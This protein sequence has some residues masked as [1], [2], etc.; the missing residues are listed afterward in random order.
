[1]IRFSLWSL[2]VVTRLLA[3]CLRGAVSYVGAGHWK[4]GPASYP[5]FIV[6]SWKLGNVAKVAWG[7]PGYQ[8][9]TCPFPSSTSARVISLTYRMTCPLWKVEILKKHINKRN[10]P[11]HQLIPE[12]SL[13]Q[14]AL[15]PATG[16]WN[17]VRLSRQALT[18]YTNDLSCFCRFFKNWFSWTDM[19]DTFL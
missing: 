19:E 18:Y 10:I 17:Q 16:I 1:M 13:A 5:H 15:C 9:P 8:K 2:R 6:K 3:T 14:V 11:P 12:P 7:R 4:L